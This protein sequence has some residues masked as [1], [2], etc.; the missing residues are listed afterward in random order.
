MRTIL[1]LVI[2]T[3]G[4]CAWAPWISPEIARANMEKQ[5]DPGFRATKPLLSSGACTLTS[6][7]GLHSVVFGYSATATYECE[8][9]GPGTNVLT[10]TFYGAVMGAPAK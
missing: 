7:D 8:I 3:L 2:I 5:F 1:L 6:L 9:S 4:I 10:Y